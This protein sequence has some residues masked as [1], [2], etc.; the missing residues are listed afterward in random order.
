MQPNLDQTNGMVGDD[1]S[2]YNPKK[3]QNVTPYLQTVLREL[4]FCSSTS[5]SRDQALLPVLSVNPQILPT[6]N[7]RT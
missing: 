4:N 5:Q 7:Y 1:E 3:P 2:I 6:T